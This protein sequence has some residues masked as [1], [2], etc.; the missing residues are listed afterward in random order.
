[1]GHS[2]DTPHQKNELPVNAFRVKKA[3]HGHHQEIE[4]TQVDKCAE[5]HRHVWQAL[6]KG[7][8]H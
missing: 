1:M 7:N 8:E 5:A 4:A 6:N 2:P 3:S